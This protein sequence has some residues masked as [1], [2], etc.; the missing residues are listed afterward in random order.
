MAKF[1]PFGHDRERAVAQTPLPYRETKTK[2]GFYAFCRQEGNGCCRILAAMACTFL[3]TTV[4]PASTLSPK[5]PV[6]IGE[7]TI[8]PCAMM[9]TAPRDLPGPGLR[10]YLILL[11][12]R[13]L[14]RGQSTADLRPRPFEIGVKRRSCFEPWS[15]NAC[16]GMGIETIDQSADVAD[17]FAQKR[18]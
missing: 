6:S 4:L 13:I 1:S 8:S 2:E 16:H 10:R 18:D 9:M 5:A 15:R 7:P 11:Q 12:A 14:R 3:L 17:D